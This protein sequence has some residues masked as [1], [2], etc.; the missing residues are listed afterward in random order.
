MQI[1]NTL[2]ALTLS[3]DYIGLTTARIHQTISLLTKKLKER[4]FNSKVLCDRK[5][6]FK[7]LLSYQLLKTK[8]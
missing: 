1:K 4:L 8:F 3:F 6:S 2:V 7:I 5:N